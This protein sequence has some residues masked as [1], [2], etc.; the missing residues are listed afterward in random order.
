MAFLAALSA[1]SAFL[2]ACS[3]AAIAPLAINSA[4][5]AASVAAL[6]ACAAAC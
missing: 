1:S 6:V 5:L 2:A 4:L 3:D